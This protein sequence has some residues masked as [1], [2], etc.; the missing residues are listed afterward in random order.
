MS[1]RQRVL[2]IDDEPM[3]HRLVVRALR[4][5]EVLPLASARE[6]LALLAAGEH[7]DAILC[8]LNMPE[9]NGVQFYEGLLR[10]SPAAAE[11]TMFFTGGARDAATAR[12]IGQ[13]PD[14]VLEKPVEIKH[15]R[16]AVAAVL[17][18]P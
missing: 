2:L 1:E 4:D 12:F 3:M 18:R 8:D 5:L 13:R 15:L 14:R 10:I 17:A 6:A 11:R 7:F 16:V 9:M